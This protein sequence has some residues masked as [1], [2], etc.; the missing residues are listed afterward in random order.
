[1]GSTEDAGEIK[2]K[3]AADE[4]IDHLVQVAE[5]VAMGHVKTNVSWID[6]EDGPLREAMGA[7]AGDARADIENA[8]RAANDA[9]QFAQ[10]VE[11]YGNKPGKVA[12]SSK[13]HI[14]AVHTAAAL[15]VNADRILT[16]RT[17]SL[18]DGQRMRGADQYVQWWA[19]TLALYWADDIPDTERQPPREREQRRAVE[20]RFMRCL[21]TL[22]QSHPEQRS[23]TIK[24]LG[25]HLQQ[26][27]TGEFNADPKAEPPSD[28]PASAVG[29]WWSS[30]K[31]L[32]TATIVLL[33]ALLVASL[34]STMLFSHRNKPAAVG[35]PPPAPDTFNAAVLEDASLQLFGYRENT[36]LDP[37]IQAVPNQAAQR[38]VVVDVG[39]TF[40][41]EIHL[42][43]RE[44]PFMDPTEK[45]FLGFW[46]SALVKPLP[47]KSTMIKPD[48][49]E[50]D[51]KPFLSSKPDTVITDLDTQAPT[52]YKIP[53][54]AIPQMENRRAE[55]I[56]NRATS[57]SE[58][59]NC[60][61]NAGQVINVLFA[62]SGHTLPVVTTLPVSVRRTEGC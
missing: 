16:G 34:L 24:T 54:V 2:I 22:P 25:D 50:Q 30:V 36:S 21:A 14:Y 11:D 43:R 18:T 6:I 51:L 41:V 23:A 27:A 38:S 53:V 35:T 44:K 62:S 48:G 32:R 15:V 58:E 12:V 17:P 1:M 20:R 3:L 8:G 40:I 19:F 37:A 57:P 28:P 52:V 29:R 39:Q 33:I 47:D 45:F 10:V 9:A 42:T 26:L 5:E 56:L 59:Y 55:E 4:V 46:S 7:A 60:G 31:V 13:R 61:L 49:Q